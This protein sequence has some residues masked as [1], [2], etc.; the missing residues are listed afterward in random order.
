MRKITYREAL[1][2]ALDEEL[3]RDKTAFLI[4]E[5]IGIYGGLFGVTKGLL[6]KYGPD[7]VLDT[8][9]SENAIMGGAVGAAMTGMRPIVEIMLADFLACCMDEIYN[10]AAKYRYLYGGLI[11]MPVTVRTATGTFP[12][13]AAGIGGEHSQSCEAMFMNCP[14]LKLVTP[15]TPY[16]AKGLLKSAIRDDNTVLFF[17]HK[18]LY[19]MEGEVPEEEYLIPLEKADVKREGADVTLIATSVMVHE[20]LRAAGELEKEGISAEVIDLRTISPV[21]KKTIIESVG[22]TGKVV[23]VYESSKTGGIGSE[24]GTILAEEAFDSLQA[25]IRRVAM[26]DI[27]V[28]PSK[29]LEHL[30]IPTDKDIF[31]AAKETVE[32]KKR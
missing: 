29:Y 9:I 31:K 14:G 18:K 12:E 2:E 21:D 7:R 5:E 25:P 28:P 3:A 20:S 23:I 16:D 32:Y 19:D 24:I 22:K 10:K 8:P 11:K 6:E 15:S 4:G 26:P 13:P 1:N 27:P 17:E 30:V